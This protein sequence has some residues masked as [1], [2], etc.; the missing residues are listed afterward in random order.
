MMRITKGMC[1]ASAVAFA[2]PLYLP[3]QTKPK[4][5]KKFEL[6]AVASAMLLIFSAQMDLKNTIFKYFEH[7]SIE[8]CSKSCS[9]VEHDVPMF[10][11]F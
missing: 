11:M 1:I 7:F 9:K 4:I 5:F 6:S 3:P 10:K 2:F 8:R